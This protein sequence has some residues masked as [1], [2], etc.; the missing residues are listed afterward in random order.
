MPDEVQ[1]WHMPLEISQDILLMGRS[2]FENELAEEATWVSHSPPHHVYFASAPQGDL[3]L[4][5]ENI[6]R[7]RD[8]LTDLILPH[9][10]LELR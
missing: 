7:S 6:L 1:H 3:Y 4:P 9:I 10:H 8:L 5:P 2:C